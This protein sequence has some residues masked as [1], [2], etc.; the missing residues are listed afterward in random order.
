VFPLAHAGGNPDPEAVLKTPVNGV[1]FWWQPL[2]GAPPITGTTAALNVLPWVGV[3]V[4]VLGTEL[5]V[6]PLSTVS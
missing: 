4:M 1:V 5:V 6:E 2:H 3:T